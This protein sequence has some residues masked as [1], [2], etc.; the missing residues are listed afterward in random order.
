MAV[1]LGDMKGR[2]KQLL[3]G[4]SRNQEQITWL[5]QAM[6]AVD[7]MFFIDPG[8][9]SAMSRGLV[10]IDDELLTI[11][12]FNALAGTATVAAGQNGRGVENT[13]PAFHDLNAIITMDPDYP[14]QRI[15]EAINDTINAVYPDLYVMSSFEFPKTAARYEYS[16][17]IDAEMVYKV[18]ADTIGPSKVKFQAQRWRFNPQ[19]QNDAA[20][21]LTTGKTIEVMDQIVPGRT[22]R[23]MYIKKPGTL[24]LNSDPFEATTGFPERYV[25]MIQ[26][27]AVSRLLL[28][29]E[30]ARLQQ[31]SVES[32]ERAPLVPT[33]A[34]NQATMM[35]QRRFQE[36]FDQER[37]RLKELFPAYQV[38]LA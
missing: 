6:T 3:Q 37:D 27:G 14:R 10:E 35:F 21:G 36:R 4:Y 19:A 25:D 2:I 31:K 32:T 1:T 5:S 34:A 13:T 16:M 12:T 30:P 28:G 26:F 15:T 18:T 20:S 38:F 11:S 33:G 22:I 24:S 7:T 29:L 23:V 9:A 8:T 17:P